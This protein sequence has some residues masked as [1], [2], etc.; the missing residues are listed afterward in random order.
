VKDL[1]NEI[2]AMVGKDLAEIEIALKDNLNPYLEL[3]SDVAN[4]ILFAGGKRL[5]PLLMV[6]SS[7]ICG[8]KGSYDKT[9]STIFEYLH[10]ATLLHDDLVDGAELRRGKTVANRIWGNPT[11]VLVGDFLLAR[12]LSIAAATGKPKIIKIIA[13]ITENMSQGE[14]KQ[15]IRKGSLDLTE[16]EYLDVIWRK[17]AVLFRGACSISAIIANAPK[18][19]EKALSDYGY[20]LGMAFQITDDLLDYTLDADALGKGVGADLKEGKITLPVIY[21][22]KKAD[23]TDRL[24]M[25]SIIKKNKFSVREFKSLI[26]LLEKYGGIAYSKERAKEHIEKGKRALLL[27]EPSKTRKILEYIA[28]Y[29]LIRK[30]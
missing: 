26:E 15:L 25:E 30:A 20:N 3:V 7:R 1:K 19:F 22:L 18:R 14:I 23:K 9:L 13:E 28:D 8:Y 27:F 29:A 10:A 17:T 5:R 6:L 4:H 24:R 11:A 2:L 21:A 12:G 16:E